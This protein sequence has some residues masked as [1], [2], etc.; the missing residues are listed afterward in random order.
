MRDAGLIF[1]ERLPPPP[2]TLRLV[3]RAALVWV[4]GR[5]LL[6]LGGVGRT[7]PVA[8]GVIALVVG[9]ILLLDLKRRGGD[10]LLA[11]LGV[12]RVAV[13]SVATL[14]AALGEVV[15]ALVARAAG[16]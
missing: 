4:L 10:L 9:S 15:L 13:L 6:A 11:N 3:G 12:S 7:N 1:H 8:S 2:W 16:P 5:G 14:T